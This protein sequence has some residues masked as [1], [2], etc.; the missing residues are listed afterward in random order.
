MLQCAESIRESGYLPSI[1][2]FQLS[3]TLNYYKNIIR[4]L[5]ERV[6]IEFKILK[7]IRQFVKNNTINFNYLKR[8]QIFREK[9]ANKSTK[10]RKMNILT[11][12]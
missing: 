6:E 11:I 8:K 12:M 4:E 10:I 7:N 9:R 2:H 5:E 1:F 3:E